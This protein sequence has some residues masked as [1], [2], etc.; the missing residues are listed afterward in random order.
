MKKIIVVAAL[1]LFTGI[2]FGQK[3]KK[4][5]VIG[6]HVVTIELNPG[7]TMDQFLDFQLKTLSR[8][9]KNTTEDG[10]ST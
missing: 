8:N 5:N 9:L 1:I 7:V 2:T 4:G 10:S 6:T 3:L